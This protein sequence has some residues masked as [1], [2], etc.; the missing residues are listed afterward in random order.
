MSD[1]IVIDQQEAL[2]KPEFSWRYKI[3]TRTIDREVKAGRLRRCKISNRKVLFL[4]SDIKA[5]LDASAKE[6]VAK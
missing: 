4:P 1:A 6:E 5:W 2:T 3:S